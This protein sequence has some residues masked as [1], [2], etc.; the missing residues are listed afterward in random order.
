MANP[1]DVELRGQ[2]PRRLMELIDALTQADGHSSRMEWVIPV[3][4]REVD[5]R[6][7][8]A[9]LL[10]RIAGINPLARESSGTDSDA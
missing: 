1:S 7:H 2:V 6:V 4:Q 8:R 3:L 10:L 9:T 5:A